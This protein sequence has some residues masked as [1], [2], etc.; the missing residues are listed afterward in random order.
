MASEIVGEVRVVVVP[1][2]SAFPAGV[3]KILNNA[4]GTV[5]STSDKIGKGIGE[6]VA[7]GSKA[8]EKAVQSL[9]SQIQ[10]LG[11]DLK[12]LAVSGGM[13]VFA[14]TTLGWLS[15]IGDST[16]LASIGFKSLLGADQG[17]ALLTQLQ[18]FG[19]ASSYS[20]E[21]VVRTGQG[22]VG[23]GIAAERVTP[24]LSN[25]ADVVASVGGQFDGAAFAI[26]QMATAGKANG[27]DLYQLISAGIPIFKLLE[28]STGKTTA[29]LKKMQEQGA[30]TFSLIEEAIASAANAGGVKGLASSYNSIQQ[31]LDGISESTLLT[32][33]RTKGFDTIYKGVLE[34]L[35]KISSRLGQADVAE[36]MERILT[37]LGQI[38]ERLQKAG[39][40]LGAGTFNLA[41]QGATI[42]GDVLAT[43]SSVLEH[44]PIPVIEALLAYLS[45]Q[46]INKTIGAIQGLSKG[47]SGLQ[48]KIL[49]TGTAAKTAAAETER[50]FAKTTAAALAL[51]LVISSSTDETNTLG[52]SAGSALTYGATA[53][54]AT[55]NPYVA[56]GA[57]VLGA[58]Q[59]AD[60]AQQAEHK[61]H[62]ETMIAQAE[63]GTQRF[64][65]VQVSTLTEGSA[66]YYDALNAEYDRIIALIESKSQE[67]TN[68]E[69]RVKAGLLDRIGAKLGLGGGD[70]IV[71]ETNASKAAKDQVAALEAQRKALEEAGSAAGQLRTKLAD[72]S[73]LQTLQYIPSQGGVV[74]ALAETNEEVDAKLKEFGL[75]FEAAKSMPLDAI[76]AIIAGVSGLSD[77]MQAEFDK[78]TAA[79]NAWAAAMASVKPVADALQAGLKRSID[80]ASASA[81][82][83]DAR[84]KANAAGATEIDKLNFQLKVQEQAALAATDA[85]AHGV[86][87][88]DAWAKANAQ[89]AAELAQVANFSTNAADSAAYLNATS[90]TTIDHLLALS[91]IADNLANRQLVLDI[92]VKGAAEAL[93]ALDAVKAAY[94]AGTVGKDAR[95]DADAAYQR[96]L[97]KLN[98]IDTA[99]TIAGVSAY[100]AGLDGA[101]GDTGKS[102]AEREAER[103]A[104]E[105][106]DKI[107]SA[108]DTIS[109]AFD[110]AAEAADAMVDSFRQSIRE[111][112]QYDRAISTGRLTKNANRQTQDINNLNSYL[113]DVQAR[114]LSQSALDSIIGTLDLADTKQLRKLSRSSTADLQALSAAV[115]G[116]DSTAQ[117]LASQARRE[118]V[119]IVT[120]GVLAA[121]EQIF[122]D[123]KPSKEQAGKLAETLVLNGTSAEDA[124]NQI[125][126]MSGAPIK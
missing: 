11:S 97:D 98:S 13:A 85:I 27:Q 81:S 4:A 78:S 2:G 20:V 79:T 51:G 74:S 119:S 99:A 90:Q 1:D 92:V 62:L 110:N 17:A 61:Q 41:I 15:K 109:D 118:Q 95:E 19:A 18:D 105:W 96:A 112:T 67:A 59:G 77:A 31:A 117:T 23:A 3:Q 50:A 121:W 68:S 14:K 60:A 124:V 104:K 64:I 63:R 39:E 113:A 7:S 87:V 10:S 103:A 66:L 108:T 8:G 126:S 76:K 114:G 91:G 25:L 29:E 45:F 80:L 86:S 116:R 12:T 89:A 5:K 24:L 9:Q 122:P 55:G 93:A 6:G 123:I 49:G 30:L 107:K 54:A 53:F 84:A 72:I 88:T 57:A 32:I 44:I 82:V 35:N 94:L 100:G 40:A 33:Q 70:D 42:L 102:D 43:L 125:L 21:T 106:S 115:A 38:F 56:A 111:R 83:D 73:E 26:Q 48:A 52:Q 65:D 75:S 120:D 46:R 22:L 101:K 34:T 69:Q 58:L 36:T 16:A 71:L 47:F 37:P 28:R